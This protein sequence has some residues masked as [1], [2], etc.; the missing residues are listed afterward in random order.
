MHRNHRGL[1]FALL[2][3]LA[4]A[5]LAVPTMTQAAGTADPA[6]TASPATTWKQVL[7]LNSPANA[8]TLRE[9]DVLAERA[10]GSQLPAAEAALVA[11]NDGGDVSAAAIDKLLAN[12]S[13][14]GLKF[15]ARVAS[16]PPT[17]AVGGLIAHPQGPQQS[18]DV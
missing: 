10:A 9:V 13:S 7:L 5:F 14:P 6:G 3:G 18:G 4:A 2:A 15:V 1:R 11:A 12:Q 8:L 17:A 16:P